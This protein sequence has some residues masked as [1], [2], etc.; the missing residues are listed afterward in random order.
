MSMTSMAV[1]FLCSVGISRA[2]PLPSSI[3]SSASL[4]NVGTHDFLSRW[5]CLFDRRRRPLKVLATVFLA[6]QF[7]FAGT[8]FAKHAVAH[9]RSSP[10]Y[11]LTRAGHRAATMQIV[12]PFESGVENVNNYGPLEL[13]YE[14]VELVLDEMRPYLMNDGGNVAVVEIEGPTVKLELQGACG[15]CA[16]SAMTLKM[17]L[18]KGLKERIP[19]IFEVIQVVEDGEELSEEG[20][21]EVLAE[22]RPFLKIGGGNIELVDIDIAGVVPKAKLSITG[23]SSTLNS[24]RQEIVQRL[25]NKF[26]TL[27]N[28]QFDD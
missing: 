26:P 14:N 11:P 1:A 24:V 6:H 13:S 23:A 18:E 16:Q 4:G 8:L 7:P 2:E 20:V 12:S 3:F 28:I 21:E 10:L 17:G 27:L 25:R 5:H 9:A 15:T 22:V 19:E